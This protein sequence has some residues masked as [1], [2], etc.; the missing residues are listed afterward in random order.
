MISQVSNGP[1]VC[2][3]FERVLL[4]Q[5]GLLLVNALTCL[6]LRESTRLGEY[7]ILT[8]EGALLDMMHVV[9]GLMIG[10]SMNV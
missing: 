6:D 10:K 8:S 9:F 1:H 5:I 7:L 3:L 2:S 4:H